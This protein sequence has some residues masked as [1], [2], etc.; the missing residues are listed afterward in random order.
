MPS[1]EYCLKLFLLKFQAIFKRWRWKSILTLSLS[2][3]FDFPS[4]L[5]VFHLRYSE[6]GAD[7]SIFILSLS[8]SYYN[9]LCLI[10][11]VNGRIDIWR[12]LSK[13]FR[14]LSRTSFRR[15]SRDGAKSQFLRYFYPFLLSSVLSSCVSFAALWR[16][17]WFQYFYTI[18]I[19]FLLFTLFILLVLHSFAQEGTPTFD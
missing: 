8:L 1:L 7:F 5:F 9:F 3:L 18:S 10:Y 11:T 6:D 19:L 4:F 13:I 15:F 14:N 17:R 2:F 16:W 12:H